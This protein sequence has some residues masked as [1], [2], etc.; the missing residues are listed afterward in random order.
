MGK[1]YVCDKD[2][3]RKIYYGNS[4]NPKV[5]RLTDDGH[6]QVIEHQGDNTDRWN[7]SNWVSDAGLVQDR[8]NRN[9][10]RKRSREYPSMQDQLD[11]LLEGGQAVTDMKARVDAVKAS[12]PI[13]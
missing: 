12:N 1:V 5:K 11:A 4:K 6:T 3:G 9:A 13:R 2:T 7:G 8:D 10:M